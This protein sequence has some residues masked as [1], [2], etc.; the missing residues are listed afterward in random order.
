M[1]TNKITV[2]V[3]SKRYSQC[4]YAHILN[5]LN[6]IVPMIDT[7]SGFNRYTVTR[8]SIAAIIDSHVPEASGLRHPDARNNL[9]PKRNK[10][11]TQK[12]TVKFR[13]LTSSHLEAE[14]DADDDGWLDEEE[15]PGFEHD[16]LYQGSD[17]QTFVGSQDAHLDSPCLLELLS[18]RP[19]EGSHT[20]PPQNESDTSTLPLGGPVQWAF[21]LS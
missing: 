11:P 10:K 21:T 16:P 1:A 17:S 4:I 14:I 7:S 20:A 5:I 15:D 12:P 13:E 2:L 8:Q 18:D 3:T 9:D 6:T 19:V